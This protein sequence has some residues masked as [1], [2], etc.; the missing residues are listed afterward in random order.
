MANEGVTV[1][2]VDDWT[3]YHLNYGEVHAGSQTSRDGSTVNWW[4]MQP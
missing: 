4:E 3:E 1:H 2:F